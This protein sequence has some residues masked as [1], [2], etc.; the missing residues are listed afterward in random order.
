MQVCADPSEPGV[1]ARELRALD[2]AMRELEIDDATV[3]TR[4]HEEDATAGAGAV[5]F[6]PAWRW[7][8]QPPSAHA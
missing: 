1:R 5:R 3:V 2:E 8:L 7:L 4:L 6:V